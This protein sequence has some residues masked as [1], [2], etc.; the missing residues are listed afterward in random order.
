[1]SIHALLAD[2]TIPFDF[3]IPQIIILLIGLCGLGLLIWVVLG[4]TRGSRDKFG[5]RQRRFRW[6]HAVSG[7]L[8][9]LVAISLLYL[10][11]LLQSYLGLTNGILVARIRA[12]DY[13]QAFGTPFMEV[14]LTLYD[15][16][17]NQTSENVYGVCGKQ[18]MLQADILRLQD[19][20]NILGFHSGYKV[21]RLLGQYNDDRDR[22]WYHTVIDLNGGHDDFF[23]S[24]HNGG[25]L[26]VIVQAAYGSGI[27]QNPGDYTV[28]VSQD[29]LTLVQDNSTLGVSNLP[30]KGSKPTDCR[31]LH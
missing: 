5:A 12:Q 22:D 6:G 8:M 17:G 13:S 7:S 3:G 2:V 19:W 14:D 1:M 31:Q 10:A 15:Q 4:V 18:W 26:S 30:V 16:H 25:I 24:A 27:F 28:S 11:I 29:A 9:L 21:T 23:N 20:V